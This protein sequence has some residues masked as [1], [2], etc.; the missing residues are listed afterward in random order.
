MRFMQVYPKITEVRQV[1]KN[2]SY[3]GT[4]QPYHPKSENVT[5][6][7]KGAN[8]ARFGVQD[9]RLYKILAA[10]FGSLFVVSL[11]IIVFLMFYKSASTRRHDDEEKT[12]QM[13]SRANSNNI[14]PDKPI[15]YMVSWLSLTISIFI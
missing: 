1:R 13:I 6:A 2:C 7:D 3:S 5:V 15:S 14:I 12:K 4:W 8:E 10:V 11:F 9:G